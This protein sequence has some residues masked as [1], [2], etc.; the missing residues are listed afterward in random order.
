MLPQ[1][2]GTQAA[3]EEQDEF[4][5]EFDV[6]EHSQNTELIVKAL[7]NASIQALSSG[8]SADPSNADQIDGGNAE[9]QASNEITANTSV[10][11][12]IMEDAKKALAE[13]AEVYGN[14]LGDQEVLLM[15]SIEPVTSVPTAP[16]LTNPRAL[17][18]AIEEGDEDEAE[19]QEAEEEQR[20]E[21]SLLARQAQEQQLE[22]E[23]DSIENSSSRSKDNFV[24][25]TGETVKVISMREAAK[26]W[27][28]EEAVEFFR[29]RDHSKAMSLIVVRE[30]AKGGW[31]SSAPKPLSYLG[32]KEDL[33]LPFLVAQIDYDPECREHWQML[34]TLYTF[35]ISGDNPELST[36]RNW[37]RLGFQGSDP[38]TDL[39]RS[40]KM[41]SVL[42]VCTRSDASIVFLICYS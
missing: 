25:S 40:M 9:S 34:S 30:E 27:N 24:T 6:D 5:I 28:F 12:S 23:W 17:C 13:V 41:L 16:T 42:Q 10:T 4:D 33:D 31:F 19:Q 36:S 11:A 26:V 38:R 37:E 21:E 32:S 8:T 22:S 2:S 18:G 29:A 3:N 35:F 20:E 39:N 14:G 7:E 1:Q 15:S